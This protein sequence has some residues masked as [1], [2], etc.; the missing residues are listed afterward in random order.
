ME[1]RISMRPSRPQTVKELVAQ[2]ENFNF[3]TNIPVKH[4][5][6]AAE[7]LYQEVRTI[8]SFS[9]TAKLILQASF[10]VSDGDFGR[11]YMM[12]YR[13]SVLVLKYLPSHPQIKDPENKKAFAALSKRI[14]R[15]IH[16]LEQIKP[17][18]ENAVKE[19]E[20]M[21][22]SPKA[23]NETRD[24]PSRYDQFAARDPSLTGNAKILDAFENQDLAV[25]L[26]QKEL[27]RRD[28]ARRATQ[29]A[30][31][32]D[33]DIMSRRRGGRWDQWDGARISDDDDLRRQMEATRQALDSAQE[34]RNDDDFRPTSQTYSYPSIA[35]PR[36]VDYERRQTPTTPSI[37]PSRP[38]KAPVALPPKEPLQSP[39]LSGPLPPSLPQ[40]VPLAGYASLIPSPQAAANDGPEVPRKEALSPTTDVGAPTLPKKE[41]LTF[42]PGAY[43]ENG[44]PIRSL[45]L[46][47]NLRQKFLDIAAD[48]TRRG[49]EMC[50]MLCGTPINNALFVRCLLIP[51][52]KCTSDTCE[53]ENEEVMFDYCMK[54]DLLLLGWIHTH[55]TQTC[56]MSSRDLHTHA[57]Y[58]VMMPESV[59]IVCAPKF[60]PSYVVLLVAQWRCV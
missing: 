21:A 18:I 46:P 31:I 23:A 3:N 48:N 40:K 8:S 17:E 28:T 56:F 32:A 39:S 11:A 57:G 50:G 5:T 52:Q 4:W 53:T 55:P 20:R 2:A 16:D 54:E 10:A 51:D 1:S 29:Q 35:K 38:P 33:E 13:H 6:R 47:K 44:D 30:G 49:L 25:D 37:L 36:P 24:S 41:R 22:L 27:S 58:Q 26:A 19:W 12:L 45:F 34:R 7:T 9:S 43:L 15:V 14:K 59:A 60:Q 42:K